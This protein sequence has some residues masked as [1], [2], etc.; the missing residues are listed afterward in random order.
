[1]NKEIQDWV[2]GANVIITMIQEKRVM[3]NQC[4]WQDLYENVLLCNYIFAC[5]HKPELIKLLKTYKF[6]QSQKSER[7]Y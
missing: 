2:S 6:M 5:L 7:S 4:K 1:M 3:I